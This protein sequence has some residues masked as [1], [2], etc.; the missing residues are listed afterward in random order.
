[1]PNYFYTAVSSAGAHESGT[2]MVK[3]EQELAHVLREKG[4]VLLSA[5]EKKDGDAWANLEAWLNGLFGVSL[6]ERLMFTRN[7]KVM[8]SAGVALPK[9]LEILSLQ[10]KSYSLKKALF[11]VKEKVLQGFMLSQAM[12]AHPSV[13]SELF[14]NM[15]KVGEESGTLESVL[16]HLAVQTEREYDLKS[17]IKGALVYPA[18]ILT[19][20][21]GI[22]ILMLVL[23][24]PKMAET[25]KGMNIQLPLSTRFVI[26]LG[27]F[28][29]HQ[30][31]IA[32][33][34]VGLFIGS[35]AYFLRTA[36]GKKA[37][38]ALVLKLPVISDIATKTSAAFT[39]RILSSLIAAGVPIVRSL[40]ITSRVLGNSYFKAVLARAAEDVK[41][42][43]K[44]SQVFREYGKL[45]PPVVAQMLEV[46]EETGKTSEVLGKLAEFYEGE[47]G[48]T[49]K[50]LATAIEPVLMLFIGGAVGFFAISM[51]Q[52]IVSIQTSL[53][54]Q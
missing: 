13:F 11:A 50:N 49:T 10:T 34:V 14:V 31:Y 24:V 1:M 41:K 22:G 51:I 39:V 4:Y 27:D 30:W 5:R 45:Y 18:V 33:G 37:F 35:L 46:G 28:L 43:A 52:P 25:F 3:D 47:V 17:K 9:A 53:G 36:L 54:S 6:E 48:N 7:L 21:T 20:M 40:E 42:G 15:V 38:D 26:G 16:S 44:L 29:T 2:A 8:V 23:V 12:E 32:F 19:A